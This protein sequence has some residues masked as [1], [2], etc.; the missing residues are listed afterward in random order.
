MADESPSDPLTAPLPARRENSHHAPRDD[1]Q[2]THAMED[3]VPIGFPHAE[4]EGY[5]PARPE[6]LAPAGDAECLRA[7]VENGADAVYF[8][9]DCGFNA[10]ARAANFPLAELPGVMLYLRQRGV[11]GYVTL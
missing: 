3:G 6:L 8:G 10:R 5:F 2:S 1:R 7:A 4:R 9:L 11:H